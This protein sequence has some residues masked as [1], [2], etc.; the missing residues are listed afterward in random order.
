MPEERLARLPGQTWQAL[1]MYMLT[2]PFVPAKRVDIC[3]EGLQLLLRALSYW[4]ALAA[5]DLSQQLS[6]WVG[7]VSRLS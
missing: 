6:R 4:C 5:S 2:C 3:D 7:L 1:W